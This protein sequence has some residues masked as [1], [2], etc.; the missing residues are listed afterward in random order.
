MAPSMHGCLAQLVEGTAECCACFLRL[1]ETC[2]QSYMPAS[3]S[4]WMRV[5]THC[6]LKH[7]GTWK[8]ACSIILV[9]DCR[10]LTEP[11]N[12][13][14]QRPVSP[15][16]LAISDMNSTLRLAVRCCTATVPNRRSDLPTFASLR[17]P[18]LLQPSSP[19]STES[20]IY[21]L[22]RSMHHRSA[23]HRSALRSETCACGCCLGLAKSLPFRRGLF[24]GTY[25]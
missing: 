1:V 8:T 16:E 15:R 23:R 14:T 22:R 17:Q 11:Q 13:A 4:H 7:D 24:E 9:V 20:C 6:C 2:R 21:V 10:R 5:S 3:R 18:S 19:S 12:P 25:M